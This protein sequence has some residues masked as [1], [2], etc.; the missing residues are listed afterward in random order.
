[1]AG[2]LDWQ[3]ATSCLVAWLVAGDWWLGTR[4]QWLG[5]LTG[6]GWAGWLD[7][8][9]AGWV[10]GWLSFWLA[11]WAWEQETDNTGLG[12]WRLGVRD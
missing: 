8:W 6:W 11:G 3:L 7:G 1:M 2:G 5:W 10:S 12:G 9:L 4:G